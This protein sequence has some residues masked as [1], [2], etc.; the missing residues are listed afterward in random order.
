[1]TPVSSLPAATRAA[2]RFD[3]VHD[4][5]AQHVL[6]RREH[7]LEH[8]AVELARGAVDADLDL[9]AGFGRRLARDAGQALDLALER[10]HAR[11]HEPALQLG[12][13]APLLRQ[14]VLHLARLRREQALHARDVR[15]GLGQRARVLLDRRIAV[16]LE[17]VEVVAPRAGID[18]AMQDL[19]LGLD[20]ELAQLVLQALH[21][22][23]ELGQVEVDRRHLLLEARAI[24]ADFAGDVQ[25]VVEQVGVDTRHFA[26]LGAGFARR[27]A[28]RSRGGGTFLALGGALGLRGRR[29]RL[30]GRRWHDGGL[31]PRPAAARASRR[32]ALAVRPQP[33]LR[34]ERPARPR[35]TPARARRPGRRG[36]CA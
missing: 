6:E 16:E 2:G 10:D 30:L 33:A 15:G 26:A 7:A 5:V 22:A 35:A 31:A 19:R 8:L 25:H 28:R 17:R 4:G 1:M 12:D 32:L 24:D 9:L 36:G 34:A 14:Q 3:A 29:G 13:D 11:A 27:R 18:V 20:L 23:A 21:D